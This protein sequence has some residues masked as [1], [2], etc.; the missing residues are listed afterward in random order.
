MKKNALNK[1]RM[2]EYGIYSKM[3]SGALLGLLGSVL[4]FSQ[5]YGEPS[6]ALYIDA[7]GNVG[8][9]TSTPSA[10]KATTISLNKPVPQI[11]I[12]KPPFE[13]VL[14]PPGEFRIVLGK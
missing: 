3:L 2:P 14:S 7:N 5:V 1:R 8:I 4:L 10:K 13:V 6:E 11:D 9:G 12:T